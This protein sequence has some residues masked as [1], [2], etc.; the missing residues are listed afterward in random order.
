MGDDSSDRPQVIVLPPVI[1]IVTLLLGL[2]IHFIFPVKFLPKEL[3]LWLG[4]LLILNSILITVWSF[5]TLALAK[6]P[7]DV[8]KSTAAIVTY[9]PYRYSR[10]PIYLSATLFY[11][12]ISFLFNSLIMFLLVIPLIY[13]VQRGVIEREEDYLEAKFGDE[14][15]RYKNRVRR[16][17]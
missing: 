5:H 4:I 10:N 6:T 3:A 1:Y 2:I 13:V 16:W 9:G 15:L 14:Y 17:I 7:Y 12:G 11:L 8:R